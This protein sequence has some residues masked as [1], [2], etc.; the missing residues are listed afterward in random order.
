M[1]FSIFQ[2]SAKALAVLFLFYAL[3]YYKLCS[4]FVQAWQLW[5]DGRWLQIVDTSLVVE[6][7][8]L[9][10]MR[11]IN[12]ALL[13]VQENAAD[14]PNMSDVIAML[15]SESMTLPEPKHPA[16]FHVRV[17]EEETSIVTDQASSGN[18]ITIS[19]LHGR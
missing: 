11:C 13:C 19:A 17:A 5:K 9:E 1:Y 12:V 16:Y 7:H 8:T 6:C 18:D 3:T 10:I 4:F 15:T 2:D 14:R